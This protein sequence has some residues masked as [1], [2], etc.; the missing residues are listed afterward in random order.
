MTGSVLPL[1]TSTLFS[2][3]Q[4]QEQPHISVVYNWTR[5]N[6][7]MKHNLWQHGVL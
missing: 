1:Y 7:K 2:L 3:L 5:K 4:P 6:V